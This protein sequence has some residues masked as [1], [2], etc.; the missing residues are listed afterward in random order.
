MEIHKAIQ[1]VKFSYAPWTPWQFVP[2][3]G[4]LLKKQ[5]IASQT[6]K[7]RGN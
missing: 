3:I 1:T 4:V 7:G 2:S 6:G 5:T